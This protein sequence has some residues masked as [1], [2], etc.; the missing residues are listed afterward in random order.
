MNN[1]LIQKTIALTD[2]LAAVPWQPKKESPQAPQKV[3][4]IGDPQTT[5]DESL[6]ILRGHGLL[7]ERGR[8]RVDV[9]RVS[10][11]DHFDFHSHDGK[12]LAD[13]GRHSRTGS[14]RRAGVQAHEKCEMNAKEVTDHPLLSLDGVVPTG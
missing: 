14:C 3:F 9:G 10:I 5:F 11:G 6:G 1:N 2:H 4:A 13:V 12:S 7:A 8:L